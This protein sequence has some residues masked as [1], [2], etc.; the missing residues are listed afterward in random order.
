MIIDVNVSLSRWPNR[1]LPLDETSKLAAALRQNGASQAW[2]GT[3]DGLL[4]NDLAAANTWL[5]DQCRSVDEKLLL[6]I[7]AINLS[8]PAWEDDVRRC[9][10]LHG[11]KGVRILPGYHDYSLEDTRFRQ[12]LS[13][14]ADKRM[15]LQIAV[16]QEDPRTQ[17]RLLMTKDVDLK[18][19]LPLLSDFPK[20]PIVMLNAVSSSAVELHG[21]LAAAGKVYFD[22]ATLEGL[23]GLE[24]QV[25]SLPAE[26]LLFGSHSP[27]FAFD[28]AKLKL[29]ESE[30][31]AQAK[32]QITH[33][34]ASKILEEL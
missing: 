26:R 16:R 14:L 18:P 13:W 28:S 32:D 33:R 34:N 24:R 30:L 29:Q 11:M 31:P 19:L 21:Q 27:F 20:L 22:I 17:H 1:R 10:E 6:P 2:A 5:T 4:H 9:H 25:Q 12:L 15:L 23:A 3:L 8:L 7:G